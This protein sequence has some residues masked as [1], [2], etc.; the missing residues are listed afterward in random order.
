MCFQENKAFGTEQN[1]NIPKH[2]AV[3]LDGNGRWA[4]SKGL[5][6]KMGHVQGAKN[7]EDMI[8]IVGEMGVQYFTVYAF[9]TEN[10]KRSEEEV[11]ALMDLLRKYLLTGFKKAAK[12]NVKF[13]VIGDKTGCGQHD[14]FMFHAAD[15]FKDADAVL[16]FQHHIQ[17]QDLWLAIKHHAD[18]LLP[19]IGRPQHLKPA[20]ALQSGDQTGA[21]FL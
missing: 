3:I 10:W 5:P 9:S 7:V 12:N 6:R 20:G 4:K 1:M 15:G 17:Y 8:Y 19:I 14:R 16:L 13:R 18:G 11:S 21:K 2:I